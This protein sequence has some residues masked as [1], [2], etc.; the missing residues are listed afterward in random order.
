MKASFGIKLPGLV[1]SYAPTFRE[2]PDLVVEFERL[3]FD[4][5]MDGEHVLFTPVMHHPGGA[6]NMVHAPDF[7]QPTQVSQYRW[8]GDDYL[9]RQPTVQFGAHVASARI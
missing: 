8:N 6:G 9:A 5:V 1:P 3:G 2:L 4:D 7:G